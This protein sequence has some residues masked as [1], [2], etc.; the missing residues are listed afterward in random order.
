[1]AEQYTKEQM[2][3]YEVAAYL[4]SCGFQEQIEK[5][6]LSFIDE[7][8]MLFNKDDPNYQII[9]VTTRKQ[10]LLSKDLERLNHYSMQFGFINKLESI[11]F[12]D[13][14]IGTDPI[15][16]KDPQVDRL[17]LYED[18]YSRGIDVS[19]FYPKICNL[20]KSD[21]LD[22][23][24][25]AQEL[26]SRR[27]HIEASISKTKKKNSLLE[28]NA[29]TYT[30]IGICCL[31]YLVSLFFNGKYASS[32]VYV[33]MGADYKTFT[34]GLGQ[35]WRLLTSAFVHG[36][37]LHLF[38]NMYSMYVLGTYLE[39][40]LGRKQMLFAL[41]VGILTSSLS[42]GI[43][44]GNT[45][46]LGLSGGIYALMIIFFIDLYNLHALSL[47]SLMPIIIINLMINFLDST[48]WIA[49]IGGLVAGVVLYYFFFSQDKIGLGVL[50]GLM[51]LSL[52][53]KY[54]TIKEITPIYAGT[55]MEVVKILSDLNLKKAAADLA[56][57][58]SQVYLKY[59]G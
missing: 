39:V 3:M 56:E 16:T 29:A 57:K 8:I 21:T 22:Q 13:I 49:H 19:S 30:I 27:Q 44:T 34:L 14:Y 55:D 4:K 24:K 58:L 9:R 12:L 51:L 36:G 25:I 11:H 20:L 54:V 1:M 15:S 31:V 10:D 40:R 38:T 42:Q 59:G 23:N 46:T 32:A 48:A 2:Y 45:I 28:L 18:G 53:I 47:S 35:Y 43:L 52:F 33:L 6:F 26:T 41:V 7:E 17:H 50:I 5:R 37:V